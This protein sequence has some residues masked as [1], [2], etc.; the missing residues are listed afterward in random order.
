MYNSIITGGTMDSIKVQR[1]THNMS[2]SATAY[3]VLGNQNILFRTR[4]HQWVLEN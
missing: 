4:I 1:T 3:S 2:S